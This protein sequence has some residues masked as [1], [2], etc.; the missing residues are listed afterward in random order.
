[1]N[2]A[3]WL[4]VLQGVGITAQLINAQ[5]A[6]I[7]QSSKIA[8]VVSAFLAGYQFTIQHLGN[9]TDPQQKG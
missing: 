8:L 5:I 6:V 3:N 2:R 9:Q 1:M 7:T 4:T